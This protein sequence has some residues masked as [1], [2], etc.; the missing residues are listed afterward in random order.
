M[1]LAY[2][3]SALAITI[4]ALAAVPSQSARAQ[5]RSLHVTLHIDP[6]I[7]TDGSEVRRLF[8]LEL[9]TA[10]GPGG[11]VTRVELACAGELIE[12]RVNDGVTGK[13]LV[14]RIE[15]GPAGVRERLL[16]IAAIELVVASWAELEST[17]EPV[18]AAAGVTVD[19]GARRSA[20]QALLRRR[21]PGWHSTATLL[22][23]AAWTGALHAG[24]GLRLVR[25]RGIGDAGWQFGWSVDM[26]AQSSSQ[27][28]SLGEVITNSVSGS[29][30]VQIHHQLGAVGVGGGLG[31]RL[32][33]ASMTGR[34]TPGDNV[35][36]SQIT[37]FTA[38]PIAR[39]DVVMG[40]LGGVVVALSAEA[41]V[42]VLPVRALVDGRSV[43]SLSGLWASGTLG[44]GW[45]W[46]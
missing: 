17:P 20:R 12:I 1:N 5:G 22:G 40:L 41:G 38:S 32:G 43:S 10:S 37:G 6:C 30:A 36:S 11:G 25:E 18:T 21:A 39:A 35:A 4:L 24:I 46:R 15:P 28:A 29:A 44:L 3:S 34:P 33:A 45:R 9:G 16:A 31:A 23:A 2:R 42:H 26:V 13:T 7:D 27:S 14:R 8:D 19:A